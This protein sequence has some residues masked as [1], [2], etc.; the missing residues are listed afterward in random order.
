MHVDD[1]EPGLQATESL[2]LDGG[3]IITL[4]TPDE[5]ISVAQSRNVL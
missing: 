4:F 3:P 1:V 5:I 2:E